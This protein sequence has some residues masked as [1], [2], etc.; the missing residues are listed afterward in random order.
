MRHFFQKPFVVA[1]VYGTLL[2]LFTAYVLLDAFVIPRAGVPA[3]ADT[4][5]LASAVTQSSS[6]Q[7]GTSASEATVTDTSYDDG[8][9][10]ISIETLRLDDTTYY[11]A[12]I[13]LA[14]A[15][16]L[17]TAFAQATYGRN[18]KATT[19]EIA[20]ENNAIFA[21]NGDFYG[22]RDTGYVIRGGQLYRDT[23][24]STAQA[25]DLVI[26]SDGNF[27]IINESEVTAQQLL[28]QGAVQVFSF[29]PALVEDGQVVVSTGEEVDQAMTS[30][31][32]TAIG[33]ISALHYLVIVSDGRTSE[34]AGLTLYQLATL[35]A[36]RGCTVAYNLD[37]GG[38]STMVF[39]GNV[40]NNPT[41]GR[42][43]A[44]RAVS[45]IVYIA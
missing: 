45:D 44:E 1:L 3:V 27:S 25:E 23:A 36:Q 17:K 2:V 12:D 22:F 6:A 43:I 5:A 26:D 29:G 11:V 16:S 38:S 8:S 37:G 39:N 28:E 9:I 20:A 10:Q 24:S 34:S 41:S 31:P 35:F 7:Q 13:Q 14:S 19:S 30:N 21:I 32:R 15:D 42:S 40:V 18:I 4:A 33:Q